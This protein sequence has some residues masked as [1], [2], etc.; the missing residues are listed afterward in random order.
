VTDETFPDP[1]DRRVLDPD[2]RRCP[3]L[4][5]SRTE[6][7]W[8]VGPDDAAVMVVGEAPGAGDPDRERWQGGNHTGMAYTTAHS[9]RRIR[10]LF[11]RLGH[12]P[13]YTNAV[14]CFPAADD[15]SNRA[16]TAAERDACRDH[17][18]RELAAVDPDVVVA[19]G[20]HATTTLLAL[21][22]RELDGFVERVLSPE[23]LPPADA[24]LLPLLHPS[25]RDVWAARLGYDGGEYAAAVGE[26]L[27]GLLGE[28]ESDQEAG[29][30][31][32]DPD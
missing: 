18:E 10:R 27:A 21:D 31:A 11:A 29:S 13:Y 12:D 32:A 9:G 22:G 8:G 7:A 2:C 5:A 28:G 23:R 16:P 14:K 19:T 25:Y 17:L 1:D 6:I 20:R 24:W 15:G 26:T 30:G 3:A 4:V